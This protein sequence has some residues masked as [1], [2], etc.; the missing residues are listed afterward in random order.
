MLIA[1][2]K[3]VVILLKKVANNFQIK[4]V[5][6][7]CAGIWSVGDEIKME[8]QSATFLKNSFIEVDLL[9]CNIEESCHLGGKMLSFFLISLFFEFSTIFGKVYGLSK[10]ISPG[11]NLA[12]ETSGSPALF[13]FLKDEFARTWNKTSTSAF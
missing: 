1:F 10:Q 7:V 3:K 2:I 4:A 12:V 5:S 9:S 13:G 11:S 6:F 8:F